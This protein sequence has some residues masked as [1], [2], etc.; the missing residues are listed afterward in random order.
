MF[1][2]NY[3]NTLKQNNNREWFD[4][5]KRDYEKAKNEAT[6]IFD[7]INLELSKIDDFGKYRIYRIYRDVRFS[8]DKTPYKNHF[9]A[10]Y[11]RK[12][13]NNRGSFYVHLEPD[14]SFVGGGFWSPEKDD[15]LKIRQAIAIEDDLE[16]ILNDKILKKELGGL[17]GEA[18]KTAPKG[19]DKNHSRI[20]LIRQKQFLLK[21]S[22]TDKEVMADDFTKK[23]IE[24][25]KTMHPFFL[26]MTD[27]LTTDANGEPL[28]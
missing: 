11:M 4:A 23:V 22:F 16:I 8:L 26:Y 3:L 19:F 12:Q 18:V 20:A 7:A 5:N 27:V 15:L 13:P 2:F 14:N 6:S 10:I 9:G 1:L 17:L 28:F 21:K 25:Y 24:T